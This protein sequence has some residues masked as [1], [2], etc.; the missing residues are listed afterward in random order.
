MQ[1]DLLVGL[2]GLQLVEGPGLLDSPFEFKVH[3]QL[4]FTPEQLHE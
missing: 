3:D 1:V 4:V 2:E